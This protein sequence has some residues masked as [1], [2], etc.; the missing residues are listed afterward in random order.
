MPDIDPSV[1]CH[2]LNVEVN[3]C[4]VSQRHMRQFLEKVQVPAST[5]KGILDTEFISKARYTQWLSNIVLVRKASGNWK[6]FVD[7]TDLNK[8]CMKDSHPLPNV[9]WLID[10]SDGY[11]LLPFMDVYFRYN[12]LP[13]FGPNRVR[14]TFMTD[15]ASFEY[16]I[17][18]FRLKNVGITY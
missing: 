9:S 17:M 2:D 10:N 6:M 12:Q 3:T 8:A 16:N 14:I 11:Q 1:A 5:I 7:Y 4:Y 18:P 15:H 13:M